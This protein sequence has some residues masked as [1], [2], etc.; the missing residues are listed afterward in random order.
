MP[1]YY[2]ALAIWAQLAGT[3]QL[4]ALRIGDAQSIADA[5]AIAVSEDGPRGFADLEVEASAMAVYAWGESRV[6]AHPPG[7]SWDARAGVSCGP[8]QEPCSFA[9]TATLVDQAR[10]WLRELHAAGL[11]SLDSSPTRARRRLAL[12]IG[13]AYTSPQR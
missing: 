7:E 8:W 11:A 1:Y 3:T 12:A 10:Y 6:R 2:L 4:G 13:L 5:I 9:R